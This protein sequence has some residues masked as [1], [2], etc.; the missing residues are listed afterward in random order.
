MSRQIPIYF[1]NVVIMSPAQPISESNKNLSNV[2]VGAFTKYGNR[3]GSYI[4]D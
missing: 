4:T 1:D 2:K 3:N